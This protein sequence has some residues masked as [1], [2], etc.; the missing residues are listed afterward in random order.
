[1]NVCL[2]IYIIGIISVRYQH[3]PFFPSFSLVGVPR[4]TKYYFRGC[5]I[6]I[7]QGKYWFSLK[8]STTFRGFIV[9]RQ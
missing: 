3:S 6:K 7:N 4:D 5:S 8:D 1:M 2:A 9:G